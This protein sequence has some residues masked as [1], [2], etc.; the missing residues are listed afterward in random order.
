MANQTSN[1]LDENEFNQLI[2]NMLTRA[3]EGRFYVHT[4][5]T[6]S[7]RPRINALNA[8]LRDTDDRVHALVAPHCAELI[9]DLEEVVAKKG[10]T[11]GDIDK[12]DS[13]RTHLS[14]ELGYYADFEWPVGGAETWIDE[15]MVI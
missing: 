7:E 2:E 3:Y 4:K 15:P 14:D 10:S 1:P 5:P 12:S 11:T 6:Q 8:R 9:R 13:R